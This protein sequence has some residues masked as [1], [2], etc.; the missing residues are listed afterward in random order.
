MRL[1]SIEAKNFRCLKEITLRVQQLTVLIGEND[2]GKSSILDLLEIVLNNGQPDTN[3][4]YR[5]IVPE[6]NDTWSEQ[7]ADSIEAILVF[8]IEQNDDAVG[9]EMIATD[10]KFYLR[11]TFAP[12]ATETFYKGRKYQDERLEQN[13]SRL[14]VSQIDELLQALGILPE[15]RLNKDA[16]IELLERYK[17]SAPTCEDWIPVTS[18][19]I[20]EILPRFERYRAIDYQTPESL[21]QKT[22]RTVYEAT[23][24]EQSE[25]SQPR[26]LITP[27]REVKE[28]AHKEMNEKI[29][30]LLTFV[31]RYIPSVQ[32]IEYEPVIDFT[33]GLKQGI[34]RISE[35]LGFHQLSKRGDGTKRRMLMAVFD[36]D[37][38]IQME[39][40]ESI[41]PV[42]RGYDEPDTNLHYEAQRGMYRVISDI[43]NHAGSRVQAII[44]THSLTM[45]DRA[46]AKGIN[47]L[48]LTNDGTKVDYLVT[49]GDNEVEEF[50]NLLAGQLG[51]TNTMLFYERCYV[52]VE[53]DTEEF[54]IPLLYRRKYNRSIFDDGIRVVNIGGHGA[55]LPF[56]RLLSKNRQ[57]ITL[58]L[59]DSD[60][61]EE[62]RKKFENAGFSEPFWNDQSYWI[63]IKEFEDAFS[64]EV[65]CLC[66]QNAWPR[67]DGLSWTP[68][69][70]QSI[71]RQADRRNRGRDK[72]SEQLISLVRNETT[73]GRGCTKPDLGRELGRSCPLDQI[74]ET[75]IQLFEHARTISGV[76]SR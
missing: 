50:L 1:V 69:D 25:E 63:G 68:D 18:S 12:D 76:A 59:L 2:S 60:A 29:A 28:L 40:T 3:D 73:L 5:E 62:N 37:R 51:I 31:Q 16:K 8:E 44:C 72:Y 23:I 33:S 20:R 36:W 15:G 17:Q 70:L 45:I 43:V 32:K 14:S 34:F 39:R 24:F 66:L 74:P 26:L 53:G 11:K 42:I 52:I 4:F 48:K 55:W 56:L 54:A 75:I 67:Q 27:L 9:Q 7:I 22:L 30:D 58:S 10:G 61:K 6:N 49:D 13:F 47:L 19:S 64:D 38:Q 46:P 21:V 57:H 41:K 65:W 35:G 71:R